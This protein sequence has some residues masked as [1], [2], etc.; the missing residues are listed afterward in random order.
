MGTLCGTC[1][2]FH[3]HTF[4]ERWFRLHWRFTAFCIFRRPGYSLPHRRARGWMGFDYFAKIWPGNALYRNCHGRDPCDRRLHAF[5]W[6][7]RTHCPGRSVLLGRF[8]IVIFSLLNP[9][10]FAKYPVGSTVFRYNQLIMLTITLYAR[11]D[12][13]SSVEAKNNL[14]SLKDQ[15]PHRLV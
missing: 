5:Y 14:E 10:S 2:G 4:P 12:D 9:L 15:F 7:F 1:A 3:P 6:Y 11:K 8:W 13:L